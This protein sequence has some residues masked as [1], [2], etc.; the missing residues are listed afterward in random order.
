MLAS[1]LRPTE[2]GI[3]KP[4]QTGSAVAENPHDAAYYLE[5]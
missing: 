1:K 5:M 3:P 2:I 4:K